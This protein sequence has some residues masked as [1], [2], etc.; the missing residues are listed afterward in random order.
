M[1]TLWPMGPL[2]VE[3]WTVIKAIKGTFHYVLRDM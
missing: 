2:L 3:V 1:K